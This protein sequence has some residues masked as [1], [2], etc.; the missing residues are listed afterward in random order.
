MHKRLVRA[1]IALFIA[2]AAAVGIASAAGA[3]GAQDDQNPNQSVS[4]VVTWTWGPIFET[5]SGPAA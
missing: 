4:E 2:I 1:L 3:V 5:G